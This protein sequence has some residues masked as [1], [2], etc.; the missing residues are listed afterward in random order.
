MYGRGAS[1][2][3]PRSLTMHINSELQSM[4]SD[5]VLETNY[6][7]L[8]FLWLQS[9]SK[10]LHLNIPFNLVG[11]ALSGSPPNPELCTLFSTTSLYAVCSASNCF[12]APACTS[13]WAEASYSTSVPHFPFSSLAFSPS[14][15]IYFSPLDAYTNT[16]L[17]TDL[18]IEVYI[19][20]THN[21][22]NFSFP[23]FVP[24]FLS[25]SHTHT[26]IQTYTHDKHIF[27]VPS[28]LPLFLSLL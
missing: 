25:L 8:R 17:E 4:V 7:K 3:N 20:H 5:S 6:S 27:I 12:S 15:V 26:H 1:P 11:G 2:E 19:L 10:Q 21:I 18:V 13:G 23:S 24:H 16:E 9:E 28:P 14:L 22:C